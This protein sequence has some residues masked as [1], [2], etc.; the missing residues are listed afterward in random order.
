MSRSPRQWPEPATPAEAAA[1]A[2]LVRAVRCND[3]A[4]IEAALA[5]GAP[6]DLVVF[7][8]SRTVL[9]MALQ[10]K[11]WAAAEALFAAGASPTAP[12]EWCAQN[13]HHSLVE[14][15]AILSQ[16]YSPLQT[17]ID[18]R[19]WTWVDRLCASPK[20]SLSSAPEKAR[21]LLTAA[22]VRGVPGTTFD[23]LVGALRRSRVTPLPMEELLVAA[24][25]TTSVPLVAML[26]ERCVMPV[27]PSDPR[28]PSTF[29]P[30]RGVWRSALQI[31]LADDQGV[32][33]SAG[34]TFSVG[35]PAGKGIGHLVAWWAKG[36][37][38]DDRDFLDEWARKAAGRNLWAAWKHG[39]GPLLKD[40]L[41]AS[42][43]EAWVVESLR[44]RGSPGRMLA[45][46]EQSFGAATVRRALE[47]VSASGRLWAA[48]EHSWVEQQGAATFGLPTLE[49]LARRGVAMRPAFVA[50]LFTGHSGTS[51]ALPLLR[52]EDGPR[53]FDLATAMGWDPA[54]PAPG[55]GEWDALLAPRGAEPLAAC[56]RAHRLARAWETP[57]EPARRTPRL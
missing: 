9:G 26:A 18:N 42:A 46:W 19:Q 3:P 24:L 20:A 56:I 23:A 12:W 4:G 44:G 16:A 43:L 8:N 7:G 40:T 28:L 51:L 10:G 6:V 36:M 29:V 30:D 22:V 32:E 52:G 37:G 25:Q 50:R 49:A 5:A 41:T 13:P 2:N 39:F 33:F 15:N 53:F 17:A 21:Q 1:H 27:A 48:L 11:R 31:A 54:T 47:E 14:K 55:G 35:V 34:T 57:P 45:T 38:P